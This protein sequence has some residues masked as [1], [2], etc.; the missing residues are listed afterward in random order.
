MD[1]GLVLHRP[2]EC[3]AFTRTERDFC[4]NFRVCQRSAARLNILFSPNHTFGWSV[5]SLTDSGIKLL[6]RLANKNRTGRNGTGGTEDRMGKL[7]KHRVLVAGILSPLFALVLN[8]FF[9]QT[10][11]ALSS[12]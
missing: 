8:V 5:Q 2:I 7:S 1:F 3:T 10:L 4:N 9:I 6:V 11:L 12:N